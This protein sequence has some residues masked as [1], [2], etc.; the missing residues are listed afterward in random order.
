VTSRSKPERV[1]VTGASRGIGRA[2][3]E[4]LVA[5][6]RRVVAV[7]RGKVDLGIPPSRVA[8]LQ[9]DLTIEADVVARACEPFGG[10]DG[11]V[12]AAGVAPHAPLDA[13]TDAQLEETWN[14][15]VRAALKLTQQLAARW[16]T[17]AREGSIVHVASTLG[18]RPAAGTL[19]Y[20][21]SKAALIALTKPA[22]PELAP[23]IRVNA[24]APGLVDTDMTRTLRL[25]PGE[26]MPT[27]EEHARRLEAQ[28]ESMRALHPLGRL[29][30]PEDVADSIVYLLDASWVT[31]TVLTV[32]GGLTAS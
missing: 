16:R 17:E 22:A 10:L 14:L 7:A 20:S 21:A 23:G 9:A 8:W 1:L 5:E 28:L 32:D 19:A 26:P 12:H 24:V 6:G 3:V 27:G 13:I 4:R 25:A 11:L 29:G 30:T 15:H 31:G 18:L 2:V